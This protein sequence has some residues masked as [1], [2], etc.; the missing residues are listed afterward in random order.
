MSTLIDQLHADTFQLLKHLTEKG[1]LSLHSFANENLRKVMLLSAASWFETR[2]SAAILEFA[3]VHS[4]G[5]P[6]I[7]SLIKKKAVDRQYHT[8]FDWKTEKPG[9]FY[10]LFGE[11]CGEEIKKEINTNANLKDGLAAFLEL[12]NLRNELVHE[13]FAAFP[14][15]KTAEEVHALYQKAEN[16]VRYVERRLPDPTLGR[17]VAEIAKQKNDSENVLPK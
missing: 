3:K 5:H 14:F 6:G 10:G 1:E 9:P 2:I 11:I 4:N 15:N 17:S 16:F 12:G 13:N 7:Q 8:Y